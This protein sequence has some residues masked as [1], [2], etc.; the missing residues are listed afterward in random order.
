[1]KIVL[2]R[3]KQAAVE[4][5]GKI[6]GEI[7]RGIC[8]LV[9]IEKGDSEDD[10]QYLAKKVVELRIFPDK[11]GKMNLSLSEAGGGVLAVSQ[12]TLAGST[13]KG[14]RP[15]FDRAEL[16][17]RAEELFRY[18]VDLIRQRGIQVEKGVFGSLMDVR[19]VND[20]PV[21]FILEKKKSYED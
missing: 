17:E 18:F 19:M 10:A 13:K 6:T 12:F 2:Q 14:R 3:V 1:M 11:E 4:V 20:G 15:S 8:L 5:Q 21:T 7:E 16:P 9:G